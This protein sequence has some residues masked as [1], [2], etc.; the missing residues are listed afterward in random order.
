M[1]WGLHSW[2]LGS[3]RVIW[4]SHLLVWVWCQGHWFSLSW[5]WSCGSWWCWRRPVGF[6]G[7]WSHCD[8]VPC[9][10]IITWSCTSLSLHFWIS[11]GQFSTSADSKKRRTAIVISYIIASGGSVPFPMLMRSLYDSS[12][13]LDRLRADRFEKKSVSFPMQWIFGLNLGWNLWKMQNSIELWVTQR[14]LMPPYSKTVS[15]VLTSP[16]GG[17]SRQTSFI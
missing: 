10:K 7:F 16:S 14:S 9:V 3:G 12:L 15:R 17:H 8:C 5:W 11:F 4:H 2:S 13:G 6:Q 1:I